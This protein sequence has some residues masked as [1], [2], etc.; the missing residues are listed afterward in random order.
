MR[1]CCGRGV[2]AVVHQGELW[3]QGH[4]QPAAT[5]GYECLP[6]CHVI[7]HKIG[8]LSITAIR[9]G[10]P[11]PWSSGRQPCASA[12]HCLTSC[13]ADPLAHQI[14]YTQHRPLAVNIWIM[15]AHAVQMPS[16]GA[17]IELVHLPTC[18]KPGSSTW[19]LDTFS[20]YMYLRHPFFAVQAGVQ[21]QK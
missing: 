10:C 17:G 19:T 2:P 5:P 16:D 3:Y 20:E 1:D 7:G 15:L 6:H 21:A 4:W 11:T 13:Q 8:I 12:S 18:Q 9:P 14:W